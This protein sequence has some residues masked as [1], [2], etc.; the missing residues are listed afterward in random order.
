MSNIQQLQQEINQLTRN[1]N[2]ANRKI[3]Q[4]EET[5]KA[6]DAENRRNVAKIGRLES[7]NNRLT[8]AA[9]RAV[10]QRCTMRSN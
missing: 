7:E 2:D 3:I 6:I 8:Q 1:L 10:C 9:N 4:K 5:I